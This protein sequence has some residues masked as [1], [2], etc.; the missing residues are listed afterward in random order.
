M[1]R[2]EEIKA[3]V[4]H[5]IYFQ[6]YTRIPTDILWLLEQLE[7]ALE[8]LKEVEWGCKSPQ[9]YFSACPGCFDFKED[10]H[11]PDCEL[12]ALIKRLEG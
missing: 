8:V 9:G 5:G 4:E 7:Q 12:A 3:R 2:L 10:G 6:E 1:T 11:A